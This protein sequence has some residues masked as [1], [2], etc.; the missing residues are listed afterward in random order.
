MVI[1]LQ[2]LEQVLKHRA[3]ALQ[4]DTLPVHFMKLLLQKILE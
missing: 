1:L 4:D 2:T 3:C